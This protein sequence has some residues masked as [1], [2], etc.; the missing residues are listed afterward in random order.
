MYQ[1]GPKPMF[2]A[3]SPGTTT[4][5]VPDSTLSRRLKISASQEHADIIPNSSSIVK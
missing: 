4:P 1:F 2:P 5:P 3:T